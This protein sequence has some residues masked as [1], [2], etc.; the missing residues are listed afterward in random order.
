MKER[1][2]IFS[3]KPFLVTALTNLFAIAFVV[4]VPVMAHATGIPLYMIEPM[5]LVIIISLAN[6]KIKNSYLLSAVLPVVSFSITGHPELVK[7]LIITAELLINVFIFNLLWE[8]FRKGFAA[9]FAAIVLSK[10]LCYAA[11]AI[12]FSKAFMAGETT[13]VFLTVQAITSIVF[14]IYTGYQRKV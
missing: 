3:I 9:M 7:M 12:V 1:V 2:A 4:F 6:G 5:R 10:I 11:Y 14:S 8:R 13:G